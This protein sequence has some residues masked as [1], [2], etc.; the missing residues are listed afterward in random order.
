[1]TTSRLRLSASDLS[2]FSF[3]PVV[4]LSISSHL[5]QEEASMMMTESSTYLWVEQN[6]IRSY[7]LLVC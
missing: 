7:L 1:M 2:L 4:D 5:L 6:V 3:Y